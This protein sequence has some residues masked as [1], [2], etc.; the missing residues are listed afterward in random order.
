MNFKNIWPVLI[1]VLKDWRVIS[2]IIAM[3][4]VIRIALY[5]TNYVKKPRRRKNKKGKIIVATPAPAEHTEGT[6]QADST[7]ENK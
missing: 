7:E 5:I 4:I 2:T 1:S 6:E 3:F